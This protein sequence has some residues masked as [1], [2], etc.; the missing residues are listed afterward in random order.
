MIVGSFN[1]DLDS[2]HFYSFLLATDCPVMRAAAVRWSRAPNG[3]I[4][5]TA[6]RDFGIAPMSTEAIRYF[7]A[8]MDA[9]THLP[10]V[11]P[12]M[13]AANRSNLLHP[14]LVGPFDICA[15]IARANDANALYDH[16][17]SITFHGQDIQVWLHNLPPNAAVENFVLNL[18]KVMKAIVRVVV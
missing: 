7:A 8:P 11:E 9:N 13:W 17:P 3:D 18:A 15:W 10:A 2:V 12:H 1:C 4:N 14:P 6:V 16:L 5:V